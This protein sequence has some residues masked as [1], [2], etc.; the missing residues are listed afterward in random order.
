MS[1]F[2]FMERM[3]QLFRAVQGVFQLFQWN[4]VWKK[5]KNILF[6]IKNRWVSFREGDFVFRWREK[7][8]VIR[9]EDF[10]DKVRDGM[11]W[12]IHREL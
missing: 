12:V 6:Q 7:V 1:R 8:A 3:Y 2:S 10:G 9:A 4:F 11:R 5:P